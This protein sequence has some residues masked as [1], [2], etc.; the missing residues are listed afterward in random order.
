MDDA[1]PPTRAS[2]AADGQQQR[3][4]ATERAA[5]SPPPASESAHSK[6]GASLSSDSEL[7]VSTDD[8]RNDTVSALH[9]VRGVK[10]PRKSAYTARRVRLSTNASVFCHCHSIWCLLA[11]HVWMCPASQ[12]TGGDGAAAERGRGAREPRTKAHRACCGATVGEAAAQCN[13]VRCTSQPA[14]LA[15]GRQVGDLWCLGTAVQTLSAD[16]IGARLQYLTHL[17]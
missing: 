2:Q 5:A 12:P 10:R 3:Q 11:D 17:G 1:W 4:S 6:R 16:T 8:D 15:R 14:A 7:P 13:L 9:P